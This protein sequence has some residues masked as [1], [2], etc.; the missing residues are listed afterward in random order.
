MNKWSYLEVVLYIPK[1]F[2]FCQ[3]VRKRY[4]SLR[5]SGPVPRALLG[6]AIFQSESLKR[7]M[8]PL[9]RIA[10]HRIGPA[11]DVETYMNE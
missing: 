9:H 2:P 3:D 7:S 5:L 6:L 4:H 11:G 10:S 8:S 1:H